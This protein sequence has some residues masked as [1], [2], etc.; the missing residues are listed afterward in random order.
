MP[1]TTPLATVVA[2]PVIPSK[3]SLTAANHTK[4]IWA[5]TL[6]CV[7]VYN[8]RIL[9]GFFVKSI[10]RSICLSFS[11]WWFNRDHASLKH[12]SQKARL[13]TVLQKNRPRSN[14]QQIVNHENR[15]TDYNNNR[16]GKSR[17]R[18]VLSV[19]RP[20]LLSYP[21]CRNTR[22][23]REQVRSTLQR[24]RLEIL[25]PQSYQNNSTLMI[26]LWYYIHGIY[27]VW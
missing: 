4:G 2:M 12:L 13:F 22:T 11:K 6:R 3:S 27:A 18:H 19:V 15:R 7:S 20:S 9:K 1:R 26:L 21:R 5:K 10:W 17:G 16:N 8:E 14:R 23:G 24:C 25:T